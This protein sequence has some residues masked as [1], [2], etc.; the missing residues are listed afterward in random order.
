LNARIIAAV[1]AATGL[2]GCVIPEPVPDTPAE[3]VFRNQSV[4]DV[5][6]RL[7]AL[8]A[9]GH[10]LITSQTA[11]VLSCEGHAD[12]PFMAGFL[13][14]TDPDAAGTGVLQF[15]TFAQGADVRVAWTMEER[16]PLRNGNVKIVPVNNNSLNLRMRQGLADNEASP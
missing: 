5:Q 8:C 1:I 16:Y 14:G 12:V 6:Q 10:M 9:K 15:T 4:A 11:N 13:Y 2:S 3:T 7:A